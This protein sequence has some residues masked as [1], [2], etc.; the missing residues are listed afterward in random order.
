[1]YLCQHPTGDWPFNPHWSSLRVNRKAPLD[2]LRF[3]MCSIVAQHWLVAEFSRLRILLSRDNHNFGPCNPSRYKMRVVIRYQVSSLPLMI[4][5][6]RLA[7]VRI[8]KA[9]AMLARTRLSASLNIFRTDRKSPY[10]LVW[11]VPGGQGIF[12]GTTLVW[13]G[14]QRGYIDRFTGCMGLCRNKA[15]ISEPANP[16][17]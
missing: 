5:V 15:P 3:S 6:G 2:A 8:S 1:M 13:T 17:V 9:K 7:R 16:S 11:D 10:L 4:H 12:H 14:L